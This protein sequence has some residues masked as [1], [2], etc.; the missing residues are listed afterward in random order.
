VE[1]FISRG[2]PAHG[3]L[4]S[5]LERLRLSTSKLATSAS[6]ST[7]FSPVYDLIVLNSS[8]K[9]LEA[10]LTAGCGICAGGSSSQIGCSSVPQLCIKPECSDFIWFLYDVLNL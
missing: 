10:R 4:S 1:C 2:S 6:L 3:I 5:V 9:T 7:S 8:S